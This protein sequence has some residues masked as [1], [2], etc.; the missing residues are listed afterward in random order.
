MGQAVEPVHL[1]LSALDIKAAF[2]AAQDADTV[3]GAS[4]VFKQGE[5]KNRADA[6]T[7]GNANHQVGF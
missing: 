4:G 3:G 7:M 1:N 6:L 5:N 2:V